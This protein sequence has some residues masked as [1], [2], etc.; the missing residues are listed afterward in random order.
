MDRREFLVGS[1]VAAP[2]IVRAGLIMPVKSAL[3]PSY[4][5]V[6][7]GVDFPES[8]DASVALRTL[9]RA[10]EWS[11]LILHEAPRLNVRLRRIDVDC[12]DYGE[13]GDL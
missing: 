13:P 4:R 11:G 7:I 9:M 12:R 5:V 6:E 3:V 10:I 8:A 1:A 2:A